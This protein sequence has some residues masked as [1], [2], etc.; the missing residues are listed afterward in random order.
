MYEGNTPSEQ[1]RSSEGKASGSKEATTSTRGARTDAGAEEA[2]TAIRQSAVDASEQL[3]QIEP[4]LACL[5]RADVHHAVRRDRARGRGRKARE[6][7]APEAERYDNDLPEIEPPPAELHAVV[8][9]VH[10]HEIGLPHGAAGV[11]DEKAHVRR[12]RGALDDRADDRPPAGRARDP[13][14]REVLVQERRSRDEQRARRE[15][16]ARKWQKVVV[17]VDHVEVARVS[18]EEPSRGLREGGERAYAGFANIP[19]MD[20]L[21]GGDAACPA[22]ALEVRRELE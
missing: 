3:R 7:F 21:I 11:T 14:P 19:R 15:P 13:D 22:E 1:S 10:V 16:G 6:P 4:A 2:Q 5:E 8:V 17:V 12:A 9:V 18:L 20:L